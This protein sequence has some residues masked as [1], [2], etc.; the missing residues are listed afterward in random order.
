MGLH[1]L[2]EAV[3]A[4]TT[5]EDLAD[6]V[7]KELEVSIDRR[8][9]LETLR[10]EVLVGLTGA[11][12]DVGPD[13]LGSAAVVEPQPEPSAA[14]PAAL[15]EAG[16]DVE[17]NA[18][19]AVAIADKAVPAAAAAFEA[20]A[21][22]LSEPLMDGGLLVTGMAINALAEV[23]PEPGLMLPELEPE[24]VSEPIKPKQRM[25]QHKKTG[26]IL[27]WTPELAAMPELEEV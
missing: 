23:P 12:S 16:Q 9:S 18:A 14:Q 24:P 19:V 7:Q 21:V 10:A 20:P 5:K 4:A 11:V 1:E 25:L 22:A 13:S 17:E 15:P 8:K 2:I 6:L 3:K 26:R 27:V